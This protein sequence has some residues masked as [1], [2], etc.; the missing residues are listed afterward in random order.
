MAELK[1]PRAAYAAGWEV[2]RSGQREGIVTDAVI[3]AAMPLAFAAELRELVRELEKIRLEMRQEDD[4]ARRSSG[5]GE[6]IR[7]LRDRIAELD[8]EGVTA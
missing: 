4:W 5:L 6:G 7:L 2:F 8:P 3:D 1:I